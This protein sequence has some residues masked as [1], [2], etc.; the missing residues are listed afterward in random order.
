MTARSGEFRKFTENPALVERYWR[1]GT[2]PAGRFHEASCGL[3]TDIGEWR[4]I[5]DQPQRHPSLP[6][7]R[8]ISALLDWADDDGLFRTP[9]R[10][11]PVH[12]CPPTP[13]R[14]AWEVLRGLIRSG[15]SQRTPRTVS[16][17]GRRAVC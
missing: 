9:L 4:H 5:L 10:S 17:A 16:P 8:W 11:S 2:A 3:Y 15:I 7:P 13:R 1:T 14:I 12:E 6:R